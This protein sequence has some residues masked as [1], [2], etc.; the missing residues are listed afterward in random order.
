MSGSNPLSSF[1]V[2]KIIGIDAPLI[3]LS[4]YITN[5]S[6]YLLISAA[7][8]AIILVATNSILGNRVLPTN[9]ALVGES[10]HASVLNMS[11][12]SSSNQVIYPFLLSL[13][14]IILA[15]NLVSNIPFNYASTSAL[16]VSLGLSL[17]IFIGVTSLAIYI[18]RW[19]F[20][21]TFVPANTPN[22]LLPPLVLIETVSYLARAISLGVRLFANIVAGHTLLNII[23]G[24]TNKIA[25]SSIIGFFLA[26][27][28]VILLIAL[29]GLEVAVAFIQAYVFVILT[30]I[31]HDEATKPLV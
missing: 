28:P 20:L 18:K 31:Y 7:L 21:S 26:I 15:A 23:S 10:L 6:L 14:T 8:V 27:I 12:S 2:F 17:T 1:A 25:A 13:F 22:A 24:M 30:S 3:N 11:R 9:L 19:S 16:T 4:F 29:V 5:N